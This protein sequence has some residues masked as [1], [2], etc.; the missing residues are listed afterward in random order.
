M[1]NFLFSVVFGWVKKRLVKLN[2]FIDSSLLRLFSTGTTV[3]VK[4]IVPES[5][6]RRHLVMSVN[7]RTTFQLQPFTNSSNPLIHGL[8][9]PSFVM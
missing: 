4:M 1:V 8:H 9:H 3:G 2:V 7:H 5:A 6:D